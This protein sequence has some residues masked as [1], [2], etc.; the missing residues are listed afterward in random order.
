MSH[1]IPKEIMRR[2]RTT[3]HETLGN[4]ALF[5][6]S[7]AVPDEFTGIAALREKDRVD[8]SH[9]LGGGAYGEEFEDE[10]PHWMSCSGAALAASSE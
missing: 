7:V 6:F 9:V 8:I 4:A 3:R 2:S 1:R 5:S 10:Q